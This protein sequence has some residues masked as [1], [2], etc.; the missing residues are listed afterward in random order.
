MTGK[1]TPLDVERKIRPGKFRAS[2]TATRRGFA[3]EVRSVHWFLM[4][5]SLARSMTTATAMI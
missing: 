5:C 2:R 4:K 1:L 3:V